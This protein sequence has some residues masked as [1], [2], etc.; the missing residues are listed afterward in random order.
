MLRNVGDPSVCTAKSRTDDRVTK[1]RPASV[2]LGSPE[3]TDEMQRQLS[4]NSALRQTLE[5]KVGQ[6][7]QISVRD[8]AP[9]EGEERIRRGQAGSVLTVYSASETNRLQNIS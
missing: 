8:M 5:E 2:H 6:M 7:V 9:G 3:R 4:V 1:S